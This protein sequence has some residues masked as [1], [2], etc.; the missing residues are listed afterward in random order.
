MN[1][2]KATEY[3]HCILRDM[4]YLQMLISYQGFTIFTDFLNGLVLEDYLN[5]ENVKMHYVIYKNV[6]T[7]ICP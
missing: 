1:Q 6:S 4:W 5:P 7:Y 2:E 3:F